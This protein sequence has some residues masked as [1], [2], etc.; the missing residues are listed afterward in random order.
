VARAGWEAALDLQRLCLEAAALEEVLDH[1]VHLI[2]L[3]HERHPDLA[4][5]DEVEE[6]Q[7][8]M[9]GEGHKLHLQPLQIPPIRRGEPGEMERQQRKPLGL[10]RKKKALRVSSW[11]Q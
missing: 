8:E 5:L 6:D 4:K 3:G 9:T 10:R 11:W 1:R 2:Q 7:A